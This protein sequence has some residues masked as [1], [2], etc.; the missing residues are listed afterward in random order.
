VR[1]RVSVEEGGV[2]PRLE[3]GRAPEVDAPQFWSPRLPRVT[4]RAGLQQK[5]LGGGNHGGRGADRKQEVRGKGSWVTGK[6]R[7]RNVGARRPT[8][9]SAGDQTLAAAAAAGPTE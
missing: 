5:G 9:Q 2:D 4:G 1:R 7:T 6:G 3:D 8:L